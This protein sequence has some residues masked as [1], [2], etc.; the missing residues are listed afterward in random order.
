MKAM[1]N[2][3]KYTLF[4]VLIGISMI[5]M[6]NL[7]PVKEGYRCRN[8]CPFARDAHA[9]LPEHDVN[10]NHEDLVRIDTVQVDDTQNIEEPKTIDIKVGDFETIVEDTEQLELPS[11]LEAEIPSSESDMGSTLDWLVSL[12]RRG[13][14]GWWGKIHDTHWH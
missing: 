7:Y 2:I 6:I 3:Q 11:S 4:L 8:L 1:K 13:R 5:V 10:D 9:S 14:K 12:K